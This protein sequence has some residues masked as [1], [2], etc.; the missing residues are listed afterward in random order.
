MRRDEGL[1]LVTCAPNRP[2]LKNVVIMFYA[3]GAIMNK[4]AS[5]SS[6]SLK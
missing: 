6:M 5:I 4:D 3:L 1:W 2:V